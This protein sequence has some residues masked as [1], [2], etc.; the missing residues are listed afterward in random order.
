MA[1]RTQVL[2]YAEDLSDWGKEC[3]HRAGYGGG[4]TGEILVRGEQD[5]LAR[6][7]YEERGSCSVWP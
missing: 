6:R 3:P 4:G 2:K 7:A 5:L 1:V